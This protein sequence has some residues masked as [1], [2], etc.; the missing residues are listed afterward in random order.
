M[1]Y[2]QA[3]EKLA[4]DWTLTSPHLKYKYKELGNF[5]QMYIDTPY[6]HTAVLGFDLN[7][8]ATQELSRQDFFTWL[9]TNKVKV[10]NNYLHY[11]NPN[12]NWP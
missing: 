7:Y 1:S 4:N 6:G 9:T 8:L 11:V 12:V 5:G 10:I 3:L 2:K